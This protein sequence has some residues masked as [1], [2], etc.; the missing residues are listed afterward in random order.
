MLN[1]TDCIFVNEMHWLVLKR[2]LKPVILGESPFRAQGEANYCLESGRWVDLNSC[3]KNKSNNIS[4]R[5]VHYIKFDSEFM[6]SDLNIGESRGAT[7]FRSEEGASD[8][9]S[10]L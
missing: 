3:S 9:C 1:N 6:K 2:S 7:I 10:E 5:R 8:F 4:V